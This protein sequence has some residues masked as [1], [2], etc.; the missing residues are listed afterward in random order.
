M[1]VVD[2]VLN[3]LHALC[4]KSKQTH[5]KQA[6]GLSGGGFLQTDPENKSSG[7]TPHAETPDTMKLKKHNSS[8][9]KLTIG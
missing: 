5:T 3:S 8:K 7:I 1:C 2:E 9:S 4:H 6:L